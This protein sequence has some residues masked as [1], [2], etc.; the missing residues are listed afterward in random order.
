[1][2]LTENSDYEAYTG[3]T[4]FPATGAV[5]TFYLDSNTITGD[6]DPPV[7]GDL[8]LWNGTGYDFYATLQDTSFAGPRPKH[9]PHFF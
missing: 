5:D 4:A 7:H 3:T 8:Y 6:E 1:M 9:R 2:A